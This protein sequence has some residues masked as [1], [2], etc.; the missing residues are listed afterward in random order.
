MHGDLQTRL[1]EAFELK[2]L[3][4]AV[5]VTYLHEKK[6]IE[7]KITQLH[8]VRTL[9]GECDGVHVVQGGGFNL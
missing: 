8:S 6:H 2:I 1:E 7:G 5:H 9:V 4:S 3:I